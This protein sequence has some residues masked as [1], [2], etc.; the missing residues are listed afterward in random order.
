M[1]CL[2]LQFV[3][4]LALST[5]FTDERWLESLDMKIAVLIN[6]DDV[7]PRDYGGKSYEEYECSY[8]FY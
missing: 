1:V 3:W 2:G 4:V 6:R 5:L 8:L 7:D